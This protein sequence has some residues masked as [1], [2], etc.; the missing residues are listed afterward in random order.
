MAFLGWFATPAVL[1]TQHRKYFRSTVKN[2]ISSSFILQKCLLNFFNNQI[3]YQ[4]CKAVGSLKFPRVTDRNFKEVDKIRMNFPLEKCNKNRKTFQ[5]LPWACFAIIAEYLGLFFISSKN[6]V[7]SSFLLFCKYLI[8]VVFAVANNSAVSIR[9][10][11]VS[12]QNWFFFL[13]SCP[14]LA[15]C[16][17][18]GF[19]F[20]L[21]MR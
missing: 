13:V 1:I 14:A 19:I 16:K 17:I 5:T 20:L 7:Q 12:N 11:I 18:P 2:F 4:K 10:S 3:N 6:C 8:H 15:D 9:L 21:S